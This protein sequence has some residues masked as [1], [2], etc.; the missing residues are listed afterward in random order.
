MSNTH[1]DSA[2]RNNK[3]VWL[4]TTI[5]APTAA[6]TVV[7]PDGTRTYLMKPAGTLATLSVKF[8]AKPYEG[9]IVT[10]CTTQDVTL[11]TLVANSGQTISGSPAAALQS[12]NTFQSWIYS[13]IATAGW[14]R[15]G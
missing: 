3:P 13:S 2:N 5:F 4:V 9:Q 15:H 14:Y 12:A 10:I 11:L 1:Y 7:I 6:T 8:P